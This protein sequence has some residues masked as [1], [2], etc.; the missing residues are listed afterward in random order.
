MSENRIVAGFARLASKG[1]AG[2]LPYI[3]AG[4]PSLDAT[5]RLIRAFA[6]SGAAAVEI[7]FPFSDSIAD[8]PVIQESFHRVLETR[9]RVEQIWETIGQVRA[10]IDL[11]LVA[12][13][14]C[15][16][17][18]RQGLDA[19]TRHCASAG[20]DGL[21]VPDVPLEE[22]PRVSAA[23]EGAGLCHIMLVADSTPADRARRIV[24]L[25]SGFVYQIA[26]S[27]TTGER[28]TLQTDLAANV[29]R[30]RSLTSLPISVGFGIATPQHVRQVGRLADGVIV[31][32]AVVRR[33]TEAIDAGQ[34]VEAIVEAVGG[35]VGELVAASQPTG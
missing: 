20:F 14:S 12:M 17:V 11:P 31:G 5:A 18:E 9:Q 30:L 1:R 6:D 7:G 15:S 34:P 3:T 16:L 24:E 23:A 25:C 4:Y 28:S 33:I 13:V 22:A 35:F 26:V 29:E 32:S 8:G 19:F 21:I 27:G 2:V 10:E